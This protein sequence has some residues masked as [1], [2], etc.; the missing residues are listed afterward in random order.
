MNHREV[1]RYWND[2]ADAWTKLSRAGYDVYR[3][4]PNTPAFFEMLPH[5]QG[6]TGLDIGCGEGYN[7]RLLTERGA[8]VIA[9]DIS[10]RFIL[11]AQQLEKQEA[12]GINYQVASAV[13]LPFADSTFDFITGFMSFM[14][15]AETARALAESYRALKPGGFMQFSI[16]HPCYDTPHRR[17]LRDD[18]GLTYAIE[19]GR[20]FE[21]PEGYVTEWLFGTAPPHAKE[22]LPNFKTPRF[23]RTVSQW[24]NLLIDTGFRL[25]RIEEPRP[26]DQ[27][28]L[29][30]PDIQ[31]AQVVA[32]Y[33]HI[34][35]R[36][37]EG[38]A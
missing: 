35:A 21:N 24:L 3:D 36:K 7:T 28:V 27:K 16:T 22:G 20:Y 31:D 26:S 13:E 37:P 15:V 9:I 4:Y 10:D 25:E 29:E 2:N 8:R 6:L 23:T 19:V 5:V 12:S 38:A 17:N 1:G 11:H 18:T 30:C 14:D 34:R 32:Y 33:L